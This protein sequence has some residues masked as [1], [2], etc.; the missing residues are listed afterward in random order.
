LEVLY[1][2][3]RRAQ[4]ENLLIRI[5]SKYLVHRFYHAFYK[6]N[7]FFGEFVFFVEL[8][9]NFGDGFAPVDIGIICEI[10]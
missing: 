2:T 1:F 5:S 3:L 9:I 8:G 7:F 6:G 10:L 4:G